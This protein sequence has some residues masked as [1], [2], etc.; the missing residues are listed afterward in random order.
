MKLLPFISQ[1]YILAY[2]ECP[3]LKFG[4]RNSSSL[5]VLISNILCNSPTI[6]K[7]SALNL[8][9]PNPGC[10]KKDNKSV[11]SVLKDQ[12]LNQMSHSKFYK[13]CTYSPNGFTNSELGIREHALFWLPSL[14]EKINGQES[15]WGDIWIVKSMKLTKWQRV[16]DD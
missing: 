16:K 4:H 2:I 9:L 1:T 8:F 5:T 6:L 15:N 13:K 12:V 14:H 10:H 7:H 3:T 11:K